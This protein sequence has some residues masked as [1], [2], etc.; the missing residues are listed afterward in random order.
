MQEEIVSSIKNPL[1]QGVKELS[2]KKYRDQT[3]TFVVEGEHMVQEALY[4]SCLCTL[5]VQME[6]KEKFDALILEAQKQKA[7]IVYV[8]GDLLE[9]VS[10]TKTPQGVL[11]IAQKKVHE[12]DIFS[13]PIWVALD[14]VQDPGNL[15]TIIRTMDAVSNC[16]L[17]LS[18]G[19]ADAYAPKT[20]RA[21]MGGIFRVPVVCAQ[22]LP[23]ML[24]HAKKEGYTVLSGALNGSPFYQ[25]DTSIHKTCIV[26]GNEGRGVSDEILAL[27]TSLVKLPIYGKAESL[28]A[29]VACAVMLYDFVRVQ[30]EKNC[31]T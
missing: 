11:G 30:E 7:R 22:N 21:T 6:K 23:D 31:S 15:G 2:K 3:N 25:R 17:V 29:G 28:N 4:A 24:N 1:L 19:C 18:N 14:D 9:R 13:Y 5:L 16:C 12:Q 26:I 20:L 8:K 27:S 10:D